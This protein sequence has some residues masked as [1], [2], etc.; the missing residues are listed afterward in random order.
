MLSSCFLAL[1]FNYI[2]VV[3]DA[4]VIHSNTADAH[5]SVENKISKI[6]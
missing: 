3:K 1:F 4:T 2:A 5:A 6:K